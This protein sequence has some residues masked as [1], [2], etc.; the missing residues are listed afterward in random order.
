MVK[1][2]KT[3][4]I[5]LG[6]G[7]TPIA[8]LFLP[9]LVFG[10]VFPS[11]SVAERIQLDPSLPVSLL[12]GVKPFKDPERAIP[13][14][15]QRIRVSS[16]EE[17]CL[18]HFVLAAIYDKVKDYDRE[19]E[20]F[21]KVEACP[22][23]SDKGRVITRGNL[24]RAYMLKNDSR[25]ARQWLEKAQRIN[26]RNSHVLWLSFQ[27]ALEHSRNIEDAVSALL[28]LN[29]NP[30][31]PTE[32]T[33]NVYLNGVL[34]GLTRAVRKKVPL[35][36]VIQVF[37]RVVERD[38]EDPEAYQ[39]LAKALQMAFAHLDTVEE[40][41][42]KQERIIRLYHEA[43]KRAP[44]SIGV[45]LG[46]SG[47]YSIAGMMTGQPAYFDQAKAWAE[48]AQQLDPENLNVKRSFA[49][50]YFWRGEYDKAIAFYEHVLQK[51][52][53]SREEK[54]NLAEAYLEEAWAMAEDS[55]QIPRAILLLDRA[56]EVYPE[57]AAIFAAR[58]E[59]LFKA[60]RTQEA[61]DD[62]TY[63]QQLSPEKAEFQELKT[64]IEK[65]GKDNASP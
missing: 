60:G 9:V 45:I 26:P 5:L 14:L 17:K 29:N 1:A 44:D 35:E 20:N 39:A 62:I 13:L 59:L 16:G 19:I 56:V 46:L 47:A 27:Y 31:E 32:E 49:N 30:D 41:E 61:Y 7:R 53:L 22:E 11:V 40:M 64:R 25:R 18:L 48:K 10:L 8:C 43:M 12:D 50:L 33:Q 15:E 55:G 3:R 23:I 57:S 34:M 52:S 38:P 58:A 24:A 36:D 51:G 28:T 65:A 54:E 42:R 21:L 2:T 37:E 63:A 6:C 4:L